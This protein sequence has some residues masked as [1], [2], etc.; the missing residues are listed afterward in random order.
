MIL[1][2]PGAA[3]IDC[4]DCCRRLYNLETGLPVEYL[5]GPDRVPR[6]IDGP[7]HLPPC[8]VDNG[9]PGCPK[10]SPEEAPRIVLNSRNRLA[11]NAFLQARAVN[12]QGIATDDLSRELFAIIDNIFRDYDREKLSNSISANFSET[13]AA[14]ITRRK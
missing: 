13:V 7:G 3:R 11:L 12:F 6:Y 2:H 8:K 4:N 10:G 5:S 9:G 1:N 14:A